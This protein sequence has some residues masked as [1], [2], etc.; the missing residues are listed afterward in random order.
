V[1]L[2]TVAIVG[3]P[4]VGK[5]T[6]FNRIAGRHIAIVNE[7]AGVTR[8][9]HY[10]V[11]EWLGQA[12]CLIDTGG[13]I[14]GDMSG[15]GEAIRVQTEYAVGEADLVL[16]VVDAREGIIAADQDIALRLR[17]S[18]K[19]ILLVVNK[20]E[21]V[22]TRVV[23]PALY[24]LGFGDPIFVSAEHGQGVG[25]LMD[26]ILSALPEASSHQEQD[27]GVQVAIVGR[28]NVGKSS[29][30]NHILGE[31]R[32]LVT[33]APGTTRDAIDSQVTVNSQIYT[34]IDTAGMRKP[35]RIGELLEKTTV[36]VALQRIKRCDVAILVL[37]ALMGVGD[38]DTRIAAYIERHGKACIVAI[39]K[40]DALAKDSKTYEAFRHAIREAMPFVSHAP[41]I[42]LS[43]MT[44]MR[45]MRLF[46]LIDNV[47]QE[48]RRRIPTAQLHDFI[49]VVTL[50]HPA[51]RYRGKSV[52]FSF[53]V[54]T[55][56]QP[57]TFLFFVNRPEGVVAHYQRYLEHQLRERFGF[58]GTPLRLRFRAKGRT[59]SP[60]PRRAVA[61]S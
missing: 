6:L 25:D 29:L 46:P 50:K 16:F 56:I 15:F 28:P 37:D 35:Q 40:W 30:I 14:E 19:R 48:A 51:P 13:L 9:R 33:D 24:R 42:S 22:I 54:Q 18:G 3:R 23:E 11:V 4:N 49:K 26:A 20:V 58:A 61:E 2:R 47:Y 53:L 44:G 43:A 32:L 52:N 57:P 41:V 10:A 55:L 5:S 7:T 36:G 39:N 27:S 8:D 31:D 60:A 17:K 34:L 12:F 59:K 45:V 21:M 1:S 38:Q